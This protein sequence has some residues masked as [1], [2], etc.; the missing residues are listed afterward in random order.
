MIKKISKIKK[1][2]IKN[3]YK[4]KKTFKTL[5]YLGLFSL[6]IDINYFLI[7]TYPQANQWDNEC[8]SLLHSYLC[9]T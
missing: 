2:M 7:L 8:N 6:K 1:E 5:F 9:K 3:I 4:H